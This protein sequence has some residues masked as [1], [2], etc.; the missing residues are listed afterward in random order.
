VCSTAASKTIKIYLERQT[1]SCDIKPSRFLI[2]AKKTEFSE[3]DI[4]FDSQAPEATYE[5]ASTLLIQAISLHIHKEG[6]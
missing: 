1:A 3:G 6:G 2:L 5:I 4:N